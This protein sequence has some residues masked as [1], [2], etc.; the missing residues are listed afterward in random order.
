MADFDPGQSDVARIAARCGSDTLRLEPEWPAVLAWVRRFGRVSVRTENQHATI[1]QPGRFARAAFLGPQR[2]FVGGDFALACR[3][4]RW[5]ALFA[6]IDERGGRALHMFDE[7]GFALGS[8]EAND[9][10]GRSAFD[11]MVWRLHAD[12]Q[13]TTERT[14]RPL[15]ARERADTEIDACAL[16]DALSV[17]RGPRER[18]AVLHRFG[19]GR[20]QSFRLGAADRAWKTPLGLV[21]VL[22]SRL[23]ERGSEIA[24]AV[25]NAGTIAAHASVLVHVGGVARWTATFASR[26]GLTIDA[27]ALASAWVVRTSAPAGD[28]TSIELFGSGGEPVATFTGSRG[29]D[30]SERDDWRRLVACLPRYAGT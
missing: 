20:E 16:G 13:S 8:I 19:V 9:P 1:E 12:D 15:P 10:A 22:L 26:A 6:T 25:G 3:L 21:R 24:C 23:A 18:A 17:A 30:G 11:E 29:A 7:G 2:A 28:E 14:I 4:D 27:A 5:K